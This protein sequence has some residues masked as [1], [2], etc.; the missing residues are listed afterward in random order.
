MGL[1]FPSL[2]V[3]DELVLAPHPASANDYLHHDCIRGVTLMGKAQPRLYTPKVMGDRSS[4]I[5]IALFHRNDQV[6]IIMLS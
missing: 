3:R 1:P 2:L 5:L 4:A 6:L